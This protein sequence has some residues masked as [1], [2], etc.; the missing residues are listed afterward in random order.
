MRASSS[1]RSSRRVHRV[2]EPWV[3]TPPPSPPEMTASDIA[4]AEAEAEATQLAEYMA[5]LPDPGDQVASPHMPEPQAA[6]AVAV[7]AVAAVF[8]EDEEAEEARYDLS[9]QD[10]AV[11]TSQ[12]TV[13]TNCILKEQVAKLSQELAVAKDTISVQAM[14]LRGLMTE[15][16]A[17]EQEGRRLKASLKLAAAE[18]ARLKSA[19]MEKMEERQAAER[20]KAAEEEAAWLIW[21]RGGGNNTVLIEYALRAP[22]EKREEVKALGAQW[23]KDAKKWV[24]PAGKPLKPFSLY[25]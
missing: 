2:Q 19:G 4:A 17:A 24:V 21:K 3:L 5:A 15:K 8:A 12:V 14:Q 22:Y 18:L 11:P 6:A 23:R 20:K 25:L 1:R 13:D 16:A 9:L 7:P 10:L